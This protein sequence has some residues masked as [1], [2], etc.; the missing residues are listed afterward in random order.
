MRK[1][2]AVR[3][4]AR[5][6]TCERTWGRVSRSQVFMPWQAGVNVEGTRPSSSWPINMQLGSAW[7]RPI[8]TTQASLI[9]RWT[10]WADIL[11]TI[12]WC[13]TETETVLTICKRHTWDRWIVSKISS[14][15]LTISENSS[16]KCNTKTSST[17]AVQAIAARIS[18]AKWPIRHLKFKHHPLRCRITITALSSPVEYRAKRSAMKTNNKNH[19][20]SFFS[21]NQWPIRKKKRKATIRDMWQA[22]QASAIKMRQL[23]LCS[24]NKWT[25]ASLIMPGPLWLPQVTKCISSTV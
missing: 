18:I 15:R 14:H 11:A 9:N 19:S 16:S 23:R 1:V 17:A 25:A 4:R 7:T 3:N 10:A 21:S 6:S 12:T 24:V 5:P 2:T 22:I 8:N 13:T 20:L